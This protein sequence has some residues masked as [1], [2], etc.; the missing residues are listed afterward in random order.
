MKYHTLIILFALQLFV[1]PSFAN[2]NM[3]PTDLPIIY[4]IQS[5]LYPYNGSC[6]VDSFRLYA[7]QAAEGDISL[8]AWLA[9]HDNGW[10]RSLIADL[11]PSNRTLADYSILEIERD[12]LITT[13][14]RG[15]FSVSIRY[16][17]AGNKAVA[18]SQHSLT[19]L[20]DHD[21][22][23]VPVES[24]ADGGPIIIFACQ[25]A[26][27]EN[28]KFEYAERINVLSTQ[29]VSRWDT[30]HYLSIPIEV[31]EQ[32]RACGTTKSLNAELE[33]FTVEDKRLLMTFDTKPLIASA[34]S[35]AMLSIVKPV[36]LDIELKNAGA[37]G[38]LEY[39]IN[40]Y[41]RL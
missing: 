22:P 38:K 4:P 25:S 5:S 29:V 3:D 16:D 20:V 9:R 14:K 35:D 19:E 26:H 10:R 31:K 23:K 36:N 34:G 8:N 30:L 11:V 18:I 1:P 7:L 32:F 13:M 21:G 17:D 6:S 40:L 33:V 39:R 28:V 15:V 37:A 12:A 2:D 41:C 24:A 27:E